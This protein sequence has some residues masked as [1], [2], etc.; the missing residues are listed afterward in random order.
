MTLIT[1]SCDCIHQEDGYCQLEGGAPV[2]TV[3][4]DCCHYQKRQRQPDSLH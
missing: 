2:C 1:C 4:M 3:V